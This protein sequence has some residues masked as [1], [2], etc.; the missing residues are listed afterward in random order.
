MKKL[1]FPTKKAND[2]PKAIAPQKVIDEPETNVLTRNHSVYCLDK[3]NEYD[4]FMHLIPKLSDPKFVHFNFNAAKLSPACAN[5]ILK[6]L[7][8][9]NDIESIHISAQNDNDILAVQYKLPAA[10]SPQEMSRDRYIVNQNEQLIVDLI[11]NNPLTHFDMS[12]THYHGTGAIFTALISSNSIKTIDLSHC[13]I[14]LL[15]HYI[16]ELLKIQSLNN[17]DLSHSTK[18]L[19]NNELLFA[20]IFNAA[21]AAPNLT[22]NLTKTMDFCQKFKNES[23]IN[24]KD[25]VSN[26]HNKY[27]FAHQIEHLIVE[28]NNILVSYIKESQPFSLP[29]FKMILDYAGNPDPR[30]DFKIIAMPDDYVVES[31][32]E[33][34]NTHASIDYI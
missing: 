4:M 7:A 1:F 11:N 23:G 31:A 5:Y 8:Q 18:T 30:I 26:S 3:L 34:A 27:S 13:N 9:R 15:K 29:I 24:F 33:G 12:D 20:D 17:I 21:N 22:I 10:I 32:G 6:T 19:V 2:L 14:R 28:R 25:F 16:L